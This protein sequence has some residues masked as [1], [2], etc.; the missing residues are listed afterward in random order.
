LA[1][2]ITRKRRARLI[3]ESARSSHEILRHRFAVII[4]QAS[5]GQIYGPV[6]QSSSTGPA[7]ADSVCIDIC[8]YIATSLAVPFEWDENKREGNLAKHGVDFVRAVRLFD[9]LVI[10][11]VDTRRNCRETRMRCLGEI[12][13]RVYAIVYTWRG[14]NRRIISARKANAREARAYRTRYG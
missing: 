6:R 1:G 2:R 7:S 10:E 14:D 12:E 8:Y 4:R 9:G 3:E 5:P 13:G 11:A